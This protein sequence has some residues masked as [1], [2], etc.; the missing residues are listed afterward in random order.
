VLKD[1]AGTVQGCG[2]LG[3]LAEG[4]GEL[5]RLW[6][7]PDM[8][9]RRWGSGILAELLRRAAELG[10]REVLLDTS[11]RCTAA[12]A[13]FR[14]NGFFECGRHKESIGDI[15]MMKTLETLR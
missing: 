8:R 6:L 4:R 2:G 9:G 13:L 10:Y 14:K 15:Y 12:L 1:A 3:R 11:H 7:R 5:A